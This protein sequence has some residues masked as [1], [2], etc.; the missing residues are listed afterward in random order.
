MS[1]HVV[2]A[3]EKYTYL[4]AA[5]LVCFHN[6]KDL[7]CALCHPNVSHEVIQWYPATTVYA[8]RGVVPQSFAHSFRQPDIVF[9]FLELLRLS[10][11]PFNAQDI[12]FGPTVC[13]C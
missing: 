4:K 2:S 12:V 10:F 6:A 11:L 3:R 5:F 9:G 1:R 13:S 8:R 7:F